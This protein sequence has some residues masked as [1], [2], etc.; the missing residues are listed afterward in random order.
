MAHHREL[1]T[2]GAIEDFVADDVVVEQGNTK[3]SVVLQD[4]VTVVNAM[5]QLYMTCVIA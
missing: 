1:E 5:S 4:K 2:L 3:K